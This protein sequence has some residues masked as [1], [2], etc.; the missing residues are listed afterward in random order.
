MTT[1]LSPPALIRSV[2][3]RYRQGAD[4]PLGGYVRALGT[5][6]AAV[7]GLTLLGRARGAQLPERIGL[8]DTALLTVAAHKASRML[9]KDAVLSPLRAPVV[10]Y[11]ESAGAG[12]INEKVVATGTKHAVGELLTCPFCMAVWAATGL[13]AGL[14]MVP[15]PTRLVAT[16]LT[17]V[18]GAD[19][20]HLLYDWLKA[21]AEK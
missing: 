16:G 13:L 21:Q 14:V 19:S 2:R 6:A 20:L 18:A 17:A 5:Y 10:Q 4:R 1:R 11:E 7:G 9:T 15:R 8:A 12:E 3:D